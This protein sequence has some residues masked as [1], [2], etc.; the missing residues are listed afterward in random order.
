[1][2]IRKE[3]L[4]DK[5]VKKDYNN[6]LE[7]IL[8]KKAFSE[9][10][11]NLLLDSL[12][13]T[14]NAYKDYKT[15]KR[16]VPTIEEYTQNIMMSVKKCC[17]S[18]KVIKPK[19]GEKPTYSIDKENKKI[20]CF[21][22]AK[23]ILYALSKIQKHDDII[24]VEPDFINYAMTNVLN[25]G[26][27]NNSIEPIRD[28]NGYAWSPSIYD[29]NDF[30]C[31]LIYQD[32]NLLSNYKLIEEWVDNNDD[33]IDY[34]ELFKT[35]LEKKY[36]RQ[37]QKEILELLKTISILLECK[38]NKLYKEE[39]KKRKK[40]VKKELDAM[41]DKVSYVEEMSKRKK[42]ITE[43]IRKIDI[44]LSDK[45][46]ISKEYETRN[47]GLPL[48][49]KIFSKKV[50]KRIL[51]NE[52]EEYL[53]ELEKCNDKLNYKNF[54]KIKK[55]Y[56]YEYQY[57]RLAEVKEIESEIENR[58]IL[59]QKRVL[60]ALKLNAKNSN[61]REQINN[62]IYE[63]R[64]FNLL[65]FDLKTKIKDVSK[66]K[67]MITTTMNVAI[68]K[69]YELKSFNEIFKDVGKNA[70]V[71]KNIFK[72]KVIR[73]EDIKLKIIKEKD[74]FFIQ[75]FDDDVLDEKIKLDMQINKKDLKIRF[76][77]KIK[78]FDL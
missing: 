55:E 52:R 24:R 70:D 6:D 73:L 15:V 45:E 13:K 46:K 35:D 74:E 66:L 8:A 64:Y 42:R 72:L 2:A 54:I 77:R 56:E 59:L 57:L 40:E 4:L 16:N 60:Q 9:E 76:N 28:F 50:L 49:K 7:E 21:P 34:Y 31:N 37:F 61:N 11:K 12:Y 32:L 62:I 25:I 29:I 53:E 47:K 10:A 51:F 30:Y 48:S 78:V 36:S 14:E 27:C 26:N 68:E 44:M 5:I 67:K 38:N 75:F 63:I 71:L 18:I 20:E 69:A 17:D 23:Q 22:S 58:L 39:V 41:K 19:I 33:M 1:L 3:K 65:P 43:K